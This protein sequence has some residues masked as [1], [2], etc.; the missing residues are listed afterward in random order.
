MNCILV[1]D[2]S[3][4]PSSVVTFE[5][6]PVMHQ[7]SKKPDTVPRVTLLVT[8]RVAQWLGRQ[9]SALEIVRSSRTVVGL[10]FSL[11]DKKFSFFFSFLKFIFASC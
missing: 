11:S 2:H 6:A 10:Y 1:E 3:P 5:L 7:A 8:G 4:V 9:I